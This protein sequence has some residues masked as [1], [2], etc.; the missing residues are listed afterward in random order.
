[1]PLYL[2]MMKT[3]FDQTTRDE[4]I[5]RIKTLDDNSTAQ[6][7]KMNVYQMLKHC[8][9]WEDMMTGK[10]VY[11]RAL[12]GRIFGKIAL[13]GMVKDDN[14][15]RRSTPTIP[16]LIITGNGDIAAEKAKWIAQLED[17]AHFSDPDLMHP[18]F[19]KMMVEHIGYLVYKHS[20]HHLRQFNG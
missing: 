11:K 7:G 8:T 14:P 15:L 20:D 1:M 17:Y 12:I 6:W 16:E 3:I 4:L 2:C 10:T 18:F 9:L 5:S 13:K 19:G